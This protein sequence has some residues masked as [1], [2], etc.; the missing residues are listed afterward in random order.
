LN[1]GESEEF[2][3]AAAPMHQI[4][5]PEVFQG[6]RF[7][8]EKSLPNRLALSE[9]EKILLRTSSKELLMRSSVKNNRK[10]TVRPL[11][12][13]SSASKN[14]NLEYDLQPPAPPSD[15]GHVFSGTQEPKSPYIPSQRLV[16]FDLKG[17]PPSLPF[18]LQVLQLSKDLGATGILLEYEDMFPFTGR[19][20]PAS[21]S[22]HYTREDL[23]A[24]LSTCSALGLSVIPLIQTFGHMEFIL[25]LEDF[26]YLR[27]VPDMPESIC[28]CHPDTLGL[29]SEIVDQVAGFHKEYDPG[30]QYIHI[31]CDEVY[32]LGECSE[33]KDRRRNDILRVT[34][35]GAMPIIWDDMLRNFMA[36]EMQPLA[37]V[38]E[39]MVWVYAEDI[40]RFVPTYTWDKLAEVF[41]TAWTASAFKG[42]HGSTLIVPNVKRHL[43]NNLNWLDLMRNEEPKF[44]KG[45]R[46]IVITGWQRYDHFAVLCELLPGAIPSLAVDLLATSHGYFNKSITSR[47]YKSLQCTDSPVAQRRGSNE[48][49]LES[50]PFL[51]SQLSWCFFTGS[52]FFKTL[53]NLL[54]TKTDVADFI[55]KVKKDHAWTTDFALLYYGIT[56][57][58]KSA[59]YALTDLFDIYTQSEWIEQ[60]IYP[61]VLQMKDLKK[62]VA[63]LRKRRVWEHR[64][65]PPL[66]ALQTE[67]GIGQSTT[68]AAT[69]DSDLS[70]LVTGRPKRL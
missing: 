29:L 64:P 6:V 3:A 33:C 23:R 50:D 16:H 55:K 32:H 15:D 31:G 56:G 39:P 38:V 65:L 28:P 69:K 4:I 27:D 22:N 62:E 43:E 25:K 8:E 34:K 47:L 42:A 2:N 1:Y 49:S 19:L 60:N 70:S 59:K 63:D 11:L 61:L 67:F 51:F 24:I 13:Y 68:T 14:D 40:Y 35:Y 45:L 36:E 54:S 52:S 53:Q 10:K 37:G 18:F 41:E 57:L 30:F 9:S 58:I 44:K 5:Q 46:G 17:A 7:L 66:P 12:R 26:A 48:L 20:S 21:A